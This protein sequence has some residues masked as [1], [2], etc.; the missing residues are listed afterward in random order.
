MYPLPLLVTVPL[1]LLVT[2]TTG[3]VA[4]VLTGSILDFAFLI[5]A[6]FFNLLVKMLCTA[7]K[8]ESNLGGNFYELCSGD[9]I[10]DVQMSR[11]V[12]HHL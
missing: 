7:I 6:S 3:Y 5:Y 4:P 1:L 10:P 2:S 11:D 8:I 9:K 12:F